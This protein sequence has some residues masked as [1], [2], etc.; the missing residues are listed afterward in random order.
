MKHPPSTED[1]VCRICG[2]T[3]MAL[4]FAVKADVLTGLSAECRACCAADAARRRVLQKMDLP[5]KRGE[6]L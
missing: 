4:A 2:E 1:Q 6:G 5:K 3:K